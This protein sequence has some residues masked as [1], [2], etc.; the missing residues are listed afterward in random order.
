MNKQILGVCIAA[1]LFTNQ[2]V[3]AAPEDENTID[4]EKIVVTTSRTEEN[5]KDTTKGT[6]IIGQ[7]DI[8]DS[9]GQTIPDVLRTT[10][11][12]EVRD[13]TGSGKTT[14]VD[15]RGFG[16]TGPSN[17]LVLIDGRRVNAIDLSNTD[18]SQ[19]N[20]SQVERIEVV[21]GA[22]SVLYGDNAASGV[23]NIITKK[24]Q[25]KPAVKIEEK[26]GSYTT[27]AGAVETSGS[28]EKSSYRV[29]AEYFNTDGYR[30]NSDLFRKDFG[31]QLG[32]S[33]TPDFSTN[34][35]WGYHADRYGL[36][37]ALKES[38]LSSL[39]RR[40]TTKPD[41]S[42]DSED[43]FFNLELKQDFQD[44]GQLA[45]NFSGRFRSTDGHYISFSGTHDDYIPTYSFTPRYSLKTDLFG[46]ENTLIAGLDATYATDDILD[47]NTG[48]FFQF[49]DKIEIAKRNIGQY[50]QDQIR[51]NEK[52]SLKAGFRHEQAR[53]DFR[54]LTEISSKD[55]KIEENNVYDVGAVYAYA[56]DSQVYVDYATSFRYPLIDEFFSSKTFGGGGLNPSLSPQLGKNIEA[57]VRHSLT[58]E[59]QC[60]INFFRQ[61]ITNEIFLNPDTY[62]NANYDKTIHQGVEAETDV[63]LSDMLGLFA[64]YT[65]TSAKFGKGAFKGNEIPAAPKNKASGGIRWKPKPSL[66]LNLIVNYVGSMFLISDQANAFPKMDEYVTVDLNLNYNLKDMEFFLNLNNI[67]DAKYSEYGV[68]SFGFPPFVPAERAFYPAAGRNVMAGVRYKF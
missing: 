30:K 17:M 10:E 44:K 35:T 16:E 61:D 4:I 12:L 9:G 36:P 37:G 43:Y 32:H 50:L 55:K 45:T 8:E 34:L 33:F 39:G 60:R 47:R 6:T 63:Q 52:L 22:D 48:I 26:G 40:A 20:L 5:V 7:E 29:S 57:G 46:K 56:E 42:A 23:V 24:G 2:A 58:K 53:Y 59:W 65:F 51:L 66:R 67:F 62:T 14:N 28:N 11:G 21:R 18:W 1:F 31:L 54:Q 19:I 15:M 49:N 27:S 38:E 41:D 13:F 68:I 64:N 25:G 3:F